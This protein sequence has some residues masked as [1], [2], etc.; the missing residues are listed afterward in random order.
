MES[1]LWHA[2]HLDAL[3]I[4]Q[5]ERDLREVID[6]PALCELLNKPPNGRGICFH[7]HETEIAE[8]TNR[9]GSGQDFSTKGSRKIGSGH[10]IGPMCDRRLTTIQFHATRQGLP[11]LHVGASGDISQYV[12]CPTKKQTSIKILLRHTGFAKIRFNL[13]PCEWDLEYPWEYCSLVAE[14]L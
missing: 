7:P 3:R 12:G 2:D 10:W 8:G 11:R 6:K 13:L 14:M 5:D 1:D 4:Q 9:L